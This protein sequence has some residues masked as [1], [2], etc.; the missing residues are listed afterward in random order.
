[1]SVEIHLRSIAWLLGAVLGCALVSYWP[2]AA[3]AQPPAGDDA[4]S[5]APLALGKCRL[6]AS[7]TC[8][9]LSLAAPGDTEVELSEEALSLVDAQPMGRYDIDGSA[10]QLAYVYAEAAGEKPVG[11]PWVFVIDLTAAKKIAWVAAPP[12][13]DVDGTYFDYIHG[14]GGE[15]HPFIAPG[16]H[17]LGE[18]PNPTGSFVAPAW[19]FLCIFDPERIAR[20]DPACHTG[21]KPFSTSFVT[22]S[23]VPDHTASG[24][25]HG[26]GWVEDVDGDGWDDINLPFLQYILTISGKTGKRLSLA[27]FD[28]AERSEPNAPPYFHSGRFY[29]RYASFVEPGTGHHDVLFTNGEGAGYFGGLYCG[30]S[31]YIAVAQWRPGPTL[32]LQWSNYLSFAKTIFKSPYAS[33][34]DVARKGDDLNKC[35]HFFGTGLVGLPG[36]PVVIFSLFV[37]DNPSPACQPELFEEQ[38]SGFSAAASA[39][40][41]YDCAPKKIPAATGHWSIHV[42]DAVTGAELAV[43]ANAYL[44]GEATNVVPAK[45]HLLLMQRLNPGTGVAYNRTGDSISD[46]TLVEFA[47]GPALTPVASAVGALAAPEV[48]GILEYGKFGNMGGGPAY[49]PGVGSSY[50]GTPRLVLKDVDGDGLNDIQLQGDKWLGYSI[51]D[52]ALVVK[53]QAPPTPASNSTTP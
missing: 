12:G 23:G 38:K 15:K 47:D 51:K 10:H 2:E 21:F 1:M 45:P 4:G 6:K 27:H 28:V 30:V 33:M 52:D 42:L 19:D 50:E 39:A 17:Y 34:S 3:Q 44:W 36:R 31:R 14:P 29:G 41:E 49:P 7:V 37:E 35:P 43:F 13:Y 32:A 25:R 11:R 8:A 53:S 9:S 48:T 24:F 16:A 5:L 40:Y 18:H 20:P 46:L 22:S 26:G